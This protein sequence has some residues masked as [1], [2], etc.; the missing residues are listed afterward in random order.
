MNYGVYIV[1]IECVKTNV[2]ETNLVHHLEEE[3]AVR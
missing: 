3:V 2:A 1:A